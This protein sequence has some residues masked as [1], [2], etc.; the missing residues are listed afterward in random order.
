MT[1]S[2]SNFGIRPERLG[3]RLDRFLIAR[4]KSAESVLD[5]V[6]ELTE[7]DI[8]HVQRVLA[9]EVDADALGPNQAHDLLDLVLQ[10]I[11]AIGK[12]QVRLVEEE[13]QLRLLGIA[14]LGQRFEQFGQAARAERW[15]RSA[16]ELISCSEARMLMK[17][18]PL[19]SVRMKSAR[20]IAGSPKMCRRPPPPVSEASA[21]SRR[22]TAGETLP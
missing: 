18:R 2:T 3:R 11:R 12:E 19:L 20:L 16:G 8:G 21:G 1:C 17:P 13:D 7:H 9:D 14:D 15:R 5:P 22:P 4:G 10:R 6:A